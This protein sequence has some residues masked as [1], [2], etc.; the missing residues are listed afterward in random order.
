MQKETEDIIR[1]SSRLLLLRFQQ[2]L[3]FFK[4]SEDGLGWAGIQAKPTAFETAGGIEFIGRRRE[5][6]AGRA[7]RYTNGLMGAAVRMPDQVIADNHHRFDSFEETLREDLKH[8]LV[9]ETAHFHSFTSSFNRSFN[10]GIC[11]RLF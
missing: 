2:L 10:S 5:P 9:R 3:T 1:C 11:S 4:D 7:D 8:V 6:C